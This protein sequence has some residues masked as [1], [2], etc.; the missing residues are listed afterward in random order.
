MICFGVWDA[1]DGADR[2]GNGWC[3][4]DLHAGRAL[5]VG[6]CLSDADP[7]SDVGDT[8]ALTGDATE[9]SKAE[10]MHGHR[11]PIDNTLEFNAQRRACRQRPG[12]D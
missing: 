9:A 12:R 7:A 2:E 11:V 6:L 8:A 1:S 4:T 10:T 5:P 3:H